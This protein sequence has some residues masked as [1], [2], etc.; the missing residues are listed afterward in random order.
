RIGDGNLERFPS[1]VFQRR[2]PSNLVTGLRMFWGGRQISLPASVRSAAAVKV[3]YRPP[4]VLRRPSNLIT[5]LRLFC[6]GRQSSLP[7]SVCSTMAVK[8]R[9]RPPFVLRWPS[10][11]ITSLVFG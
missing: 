4:Y 5:G 1:F 7:A 9:Y 10:K 3:R 6:G 2:R 11:L 8:A